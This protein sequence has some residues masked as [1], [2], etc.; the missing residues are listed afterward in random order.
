M[1]PGVHPGRA[2]GATGASGSLELVL[3]RLE[4]DVAVLAGV[5][6]E[7][8]EDFNLGRCD[9]NLVWWC[10]GHLVW[11]TTIGGVW[12]IVSAQDSGG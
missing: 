9:W 2:P 3:G 10:L 7:P 1:I 11:W 12:D 6:L 5:G 8:G 4:G